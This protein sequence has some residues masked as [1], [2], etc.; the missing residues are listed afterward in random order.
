MTAERIARALG[1]KPYDD[2]WLIRCP[3]PDHGA[4]RGDKHPSCIVKDGDVPGRILVKCFATCTNDQ[5]LDALR[6]RGLLDDEPAR[7]QTHRH[8]KPA[9]RPLPR[10]EP[11]PDPKALRLWLAAKA[12]SGTIAET[13]LREHRGITIDLP[14]SLRFGYAFHSPTGLE[15]PALIAAIARPHDRK[16]IAVQCTF[17]TERGAKS[18][19]N[20][21]RLNFGSFGTGAVRLAAVADIIG[22][23]EGVEKALAAMQLTGIPCWSTAGAG[24]LATVTVQ[25]SA[26]TVHLFCDNDEPG[27]VAAKLATNRF[28][29]EGR[30]VVVR[31]PPDGVKDYDAITKARSAEA[32]A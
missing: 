1:G 4:G 5:I 21:P 18:P 12:I 23:S 26:H 25:D 14:P 2:G 3:A 32:A 29:R 11:N 7:T 16:I 30:K 20:K 22:I 17:L 13:Y 19:L 27:R 9:R 24:R 10:P 15:L 31:F 8:Q 6:S 28:T